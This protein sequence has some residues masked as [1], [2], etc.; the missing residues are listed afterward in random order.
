MISLFNMLPDEKKRH[1]TFGLMDMFEGVKDAILPI[2]SNTPYGSAT[3]KIKEH[4]RDFTRELGEGLYHD[5]PQGVIDL[6][7]DIINRGGNLLGVEGDFIDRKSVQVVP[8]VFDE[9][10]R[11]KLGM[12]S[13]EEDSVGRIL[14]QLLGG[15]AGIRGVLSKG[16]MSEAVAVSG[17]GSTLDPTKPNLSNFI[18]DT[19][20][21]NLLFEYMSAGV[22]EE[23][24]AEER[25]LARV[26]NMTEEL[27]LAFI[28]LGLIQGLRAMK[29]NP[30]IKEEILDTFHPDRMGGLL[31]DKTGLITDYRAFAVP[32]KPKISGLTGRVE[33]TGVP[34]AQVDDAGFYLKS[35]QQILAM[36]QNQM[37]ASQVEGFLK[38]RG[39][40]PS[41][42]K[43]LGLL[44][45][46]DG[47][48]EGDHN[49]YW[50]S[51]TGRSTGY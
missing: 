31:S 50:G 22:P 12:K 21:N 14:G 34:S 13:L 18:Q 49:G 47:L 43:D 20:F 17:A 6:G 35:E 5:L 15:Y 19:R 26:G 27:G 16:L 37:P 44:D 42:M 4:G 51:T 38:K 1:N 24:G 23:A 7:T 30:A 29:N 36:P 41:E 33:E 25:L 48:P 32:E 46:L 2:L 11:K 10:E 45:M 40:S 28:P 3:R 8:P 9:E 39:V